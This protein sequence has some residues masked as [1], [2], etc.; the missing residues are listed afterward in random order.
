[1]VTHDA[2]VAHAAGR[3]VRMRDGRIAEPQPGDDRVGPASTAQARI[4]PASPAAAGAS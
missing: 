3:V 1:M 4:G 2:N